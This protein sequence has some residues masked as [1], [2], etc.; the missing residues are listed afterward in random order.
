MC[1]STKQMSQQG[2]TRIVLIISFAI[3][4]K[5]KIVVIK[6]CCN[7][8]EKQYST[9]QKVLQKQKMSNSAPKHALQL[10]SQLIVSHLHSKT[11]YRGSISYSKCYEVKR[12]MHKKL[13][14]YS[15]IC[16]YIF[17]NTNIMGYSIGSK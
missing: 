8:K 13:Q 12:Q 9:E 11:F 15:D 3:T 14:I 17:L 6:Q 7:N 5:N 1:F 4:R 16:S 10:C 2:K